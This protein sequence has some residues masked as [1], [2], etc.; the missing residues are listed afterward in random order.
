MSAAS[1][2]RSWYSRVGVLAIFCG[3][4]GLSLIYDAMPP[5]VVEVAKHFG[6]GERGMIVAQLA[7]SLPYF[8]V[9]LAGLLA[10]FPVKWWGHR[11][12]LLV[13]LIMYG[14]L[15]SAGAII[16]DAS[17]LLVT[18]LGLGFAVG[19]LITCCMGYVAV[20]FDDAHRARLAGWMLAC[21][22]ACGVIFI[23]VSGFVAAAF[24][25]RAPF[26]LHLLIS[27]FFLVPVLCMDRAK[28]V[29]T[30]EKAPLSLNQLNP[31]VV[32][33][34][35]AFVLQLTVGIFFV[36]SA[37]LIGEMPFGSS[38]MIGVIFA[39]VGVSSSL[40]AYSYGRWFV[41]VPPTVVNAAGFLLT[42]AGMVV[43]ALAWTLPS[44]LL[45]AV[46]YGMGS[47]IAQASLFTW[48][49]QKSPP[50]LLTNVMGLVFTSLYLGIAIG[51]TLA[52]P[53]PMII[54]IRNIFLILACGIFLGVGIAW[55]FQRRH[56]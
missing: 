23:L 34:A 42:G 46:L 30:H 32:V 51:P 44:F 11:N 38:Q 3:H 10:P 16:D 48:A 19:S 9:M 25:W 39:V 54:G 26:L 7:S 21:G 14:L 8:G 1:L 53:L 5:I 31:V 6:G 49:M 50:A 12:V 45:S 41:H 13:N 27:G 47:A 43:A 4:A 17:L 33:F 2:P 52:A 36:Q 24:G 40:S 28:P 56:R 35:T 18:R 29:A 15:G 37:F 22:G 55:S 20:K